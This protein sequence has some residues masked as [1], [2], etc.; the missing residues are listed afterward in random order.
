MSKALLSF[1]L[2]PVQGFIEASRSVRD[3]K[4]GS[5]ILSDLTMAAIDAAKSAGGQLLFPAE[6]PPGGASGIPNQFIARYNDV[7]SAEE[8]RTQCKEAATARWLAIA[9]AVRDALAP[10]L[11][12]ISA[13]WA[14]GW[15]DQLARYWDIHTAVLDLD[16]T[17]TTLAAFE[18]QKPDT[19]DLAEQIRAVQLLMSASKMQ[20]HF[21]GDHGIGRHKCA[22]MG[23]WEQMGPAGLGRANDFWSTAAS[24][25]SIRG[26]R[27]SPRDRLCAPAL[28]KRFSGLDKQLAGKLGGAI[29]D[30]AA[31][32]T[33]AWWRAAETD[34]ADRCKAFSAAADALAHKL[35]DAADTKRRYLLDDDLSAESIKRDL[36]DVDVEIESEVNSLREARKSL[37]DAARDRQGAPPRYYAILVQDG[38][39]MGKWLSGA[40]TAGK[41]TDKFLSQLST[42]LQNY[43]ANV[44]TTVVQH[45]GYPVYAGGD[46]ALAMLPLSEA[47]RCARELR[48]AFPNF[49]VAAGQGPTLSA[50]LAIV[51]YMHDLRA[52]LKAARAAEAK[53]KMQGRDALSICLLKRSGGPVELTLPW[54][55]LEKL[56]KL[57]GLFHAGLSDGWVSRLA[58]LAPAFDGPDPYLGA[59]PMKCMIGHVARGLQLSDE[60][61]LRIAQELCIADPQDAEDACREWLKDLWQ[62]IWNATDRRFELLRNNGASADQ[63]PDSEQVGFFQAVKDAFLKFG[64]VASFLDRGRD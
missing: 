58:M 31:V 44:V 32:A 37:L 18:G 7:E 41:L 15:D 54:C 1:S 28:V 36:G 63:F 34:C 52:A 42:Q 64:L 38:D 59:E 48:G 2:T 8:A 11:E 62:C 33:E 5:V 12:K 17:A 20:R 6:P 3:L 43:A 47:V 10:Q 35:G 51:H 61:K 29:P 53:A 57:Q 4:A 26:V 46:D 19:I 56:A 13:D 9:K 25:L 50:G 22:I 40:K 55:L 60:D 49:G 27:L 16:A 23:E 24:R 39:E 21:P 14:Q 30:T 45:H